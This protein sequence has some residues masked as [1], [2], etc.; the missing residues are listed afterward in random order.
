M[1]GTTKKLISA[2][3]LAAMVTA[4]SCSNKDPKNIGTPESTVA[5]ATSVDGLFPTGDKS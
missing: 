1:N 3:L 2:V 4:A 5:P